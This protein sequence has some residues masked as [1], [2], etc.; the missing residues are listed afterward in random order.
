MSRR[1]TKLQIED[2]VAIVTLN[3]PD[4]LNTFTGAM[5]SELA[6]AYAEVGQF[7]SATNYANQ[8]LSLAHAADEAP[9]R[10]RPPRLSREAIL[11]AALTLLEHEPR[12]PL[13]VARTRKR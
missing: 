4:H 6:A 2:R 11:G 9:R 13:T 7:A 3:R 12:E 5:G 1:D 8:A 10:G